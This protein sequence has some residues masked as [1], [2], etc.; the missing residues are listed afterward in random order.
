M[1]LADDQCPDV[2]HLFIRH[3]WV[4]GATESLSS[5]A[6]PAHLPQQQRR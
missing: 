3:G 1:N 2:G 5:L 4:G 6:S